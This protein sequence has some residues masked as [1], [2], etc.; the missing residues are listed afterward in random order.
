M[1]AEHATNSDGTNSVE[2][3]VLDM[4]ER[5][6]DGRWRVF[7]GVCPLWMEEKRL[8]HR[9]EGKIVKEYDDLIS[10][11]RYAMMMLRHARIGRVTRNP[12]GFDERGGPGRQ[13]LGTG[14]VSW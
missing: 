10:A 3:A 7:D 13:A 2:A 5:M 4:L 9:D 14:E 8:Y 6:N 12:F 11:S 1:L